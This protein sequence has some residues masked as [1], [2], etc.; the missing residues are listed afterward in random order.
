VTSTHDGRID[1]LDASAPARLPSS[2][3]AETVGADGMRAMTDETDLDIRTRERQIV[4][5]F[6][7]LADTLVEDF[8]LVE[9][10]AS[11]TERVVGLGIA[12]E[13]GILLVDETGDPQFLAAS[14]ERTQMLELFQVQAEEGP[15]QDCFTKG[16]PVSV[17]D[18]AET[19]DRWPNFA[20][21]ALASGFRSV[22]AVPLRLRGTILGAMNLFLTEPGGISADSLTVIQAMADVATIGLLQQRELHRAHTVESQLQHALHSRIGIEQA[23]GIISEQAHVTTDAAF[24]LMRRYSRD[25][26]RKLAAVANEIVEGTVTATELTTAR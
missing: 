19:H 18:L 26:N 15:C 1:A 25:N 13:V 5:T 22:Q 4:M 23:K 16:V 2:R 20:P 21:R 6:V 24:D 11:L 14:H 3:T 17:I 9:F 7:E 12:N 8:D 10:L